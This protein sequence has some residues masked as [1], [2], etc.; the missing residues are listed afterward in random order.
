[1]G[2]DAVELLSEVEETFGITITDQEAQDVRTVGQ[3][4]DLILAKLPKSEACASMIAFYRLRRGLMALGA[5]RDVAT[6][7]ALLAAL[8][9]LRGRQRAWQKLAD[10]SQLKLPSLRKPLAVK[11]SVVVLTLLA[12]VVALY[13]GAGFFSFWAVVIVGVLFSSLSRLVAVLLPHRC[14][15][16]GHLAQLL[17]DRYPSL[18]ATTRPTPA[19]A[20][21]QLVN[22]IATIGG[23]A[24][25]RV[26]P[27]ARLLDDLGIG[28]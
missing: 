11:V 4:Y 19:V 17:A 18:A 28:G 10:V 1:M 13:L 2:L 3:F 22:A 8:L 27:E 9:P 12:G 7:D 24:A 14:A 20:W 23:V 16:V 15:T 25:A 5:S 26:T 6:P 21:Q